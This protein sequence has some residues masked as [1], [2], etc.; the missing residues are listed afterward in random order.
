M[1]ISA[2]SSDC[3]DRIVGEENQRRAARFSWETHI[4]RLLKVYDETLS[5]HRAKRRHA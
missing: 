4:E 1:T 3:E 2:I 5:A